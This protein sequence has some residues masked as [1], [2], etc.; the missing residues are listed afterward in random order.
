MCACILMH[1]VCMCVCVHLDIKGQF[2]ITSITFHSLINWDDL[3][4][5]VDLV[6]SARLAGQQGAPETL[7]SPLDMAST[8]VKGRH[9]CAQLCCGCWGSRLRWPCMLSKHF[10]HWPIFPVPRRKVKPVEVLTYASIHPCVHAPMHPCTHV[11][12]HPCV[13]AP[14]HPC[15]HV[16]MHL[17]ICAPIHLCTHVPMYP[18]TSASMHSY[19]H[20]PML[21]SC[22]TCTHECASCG[23][24]R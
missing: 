18:C 14:L 21:R 22:I 9:H 11:P 16:Y 2:G 17:C 8:G 23:E 6:I 7:L 19:T 13:H 15:T 5:D 3:L 12:M 4:L 24:E 20:A 10:T 1:A